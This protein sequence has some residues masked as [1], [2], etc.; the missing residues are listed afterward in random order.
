[1]N[2][3]SETL[4]LI[5]F[6][7]SSLLQDVRY[8]SF[9]PRQFL[10]DLILPIIPMSKT[11]TKILDVLCYK[12]NNKPVIDFNIP[13]FD[14]FSLIAENSYP[15]YGKIKT[16]PSS[17]PVCVRLDTPENV[18]T[19]LKALDIKIFEFQGYNVAW[20]YHYNFDCDILVFADG[21]YIGKPFYILNNLQN[22]FSSIPWTPIGYFPTIKNNDY[23]LCYWILVSEKVHKHLDILT[24]IFKKNILVWVENP[25]YYDNFSNHE[26]NG[27]VL[28]YGYGINKGK[29]FYSKS[30]YS[31]DF[32]KY[33]PLGYKPTYELSK[34]SNL[35]VWILIHET[36]IKY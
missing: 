25:Y 22:L 10:S 21:S 2:S 32:E 1:M 12:D 6:D 19:N 35:Y 33:C 20:V 29:R 9:E 27:Y 14:I 30:V 24:F 11:S 8:I 18:F 17:Y 5:D 15:Y 36:E 3:K 7:K 13:L 28:I 23:Q 16:Y 4:K 31:N 34:I 26:F